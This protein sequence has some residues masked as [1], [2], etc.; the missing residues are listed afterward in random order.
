MPLS[1]RE[2]EIL[3]EI[4]RNLQEEDPLARARGRRSR[5]PSSESNRFKLAVFVFIMGLMILI[6]FFVSELVVVGVIAFVTMVSAIVLGASSLA[7]MFSARSDEPGRVSR[8]L[9]DW[10]ERVRRRYRG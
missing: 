3:A 6:G 10:E 5:T 8:T 2:Q 1:E 4:E 7:A 9:S